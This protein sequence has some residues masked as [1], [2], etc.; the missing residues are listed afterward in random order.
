MTTTRT[1]GMCIEQQGDGPAVILLHGLGATSNSF[2]PLMPALGGR[3]V[4]RPDLPGAGRSPTP[5]AGLDLRGLVDAV[6]RMADELGVREA[7]LVGH[8]FGSLIAQHVAQARPALA[9]TLTLFGP[10]IEPADAARERLRARAGLAR[11]QGMDVVGEQMAAGGLASG[12]AETNAAAVAFVRESHMRQDA[13]GFAQNCEALAG[14]HRAD[15]GALKMPVLIVTGEE[16]GVGP[17][18]VAHQLADELAQGRAV[19]LPG[20]G[21][22]TPIEKPA[23]CRLALTEHL[24]RG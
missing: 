8:S 1:A 24:G 23:D 3:R 17:P 10:L 7:D 11:E 12:A 21:H 19:V 9:R 20:C 18:S 2:Q 13:E 16:D 22:W 6:L 5:R 15:P 14:A 4:I